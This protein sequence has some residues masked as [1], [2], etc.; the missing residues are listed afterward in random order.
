METKLGTGQG[1]DDTLFFRYPHLN[2][3]STVG[4]SKFRK[5][6]FGHILR[7]HENSPAYFSMLFAVNA[8]KIYNSSKS[9]KPF[10][11]PREAQFHVLSF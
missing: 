5:R 10:V 7:G 6:M 8:D 4:L 2:L 3:V 11:F 1:F 9:N